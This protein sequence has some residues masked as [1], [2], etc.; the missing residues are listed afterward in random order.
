MPGLKTKEE[1]GPLATAVSLALTILRRAKANTW[2]E[3]GDAMA[4]EDPAAVKALQA[5]DLTDTQLALIGEHAN[6]LPLIRL[7]PPAIPAVCPV[8]GQFVLV[9]AQTPSKCLVT[10][11]CA[12]KPVKVG[13]AVTAKPSPGGED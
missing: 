13:A 10:G 11:G 12:G 7:T 3:L 2:E 6:I 1:Y 5:I 4:S 8:C 9:A